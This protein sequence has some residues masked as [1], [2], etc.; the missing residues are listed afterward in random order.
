MLQRLAPRVPVGLVGDRE[1]DIIGAHA[2]GIGGF[3]V[4][5]GYGS[6]AELEAAGADTLL[7]APADVATLVE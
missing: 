4:L 2:H 3:G 1:H 6:R 5:W 7:A